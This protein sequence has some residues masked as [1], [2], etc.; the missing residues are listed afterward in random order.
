M[1][2]DTSQD[3]VC[4]FWDGVKLRFH[5]INCCILGELSGNEPGCNHI[6]PIV[7][8]VELEQSC[9]CETTS[10]LNRTGQFKTERTRT[11]KTNFGAR[12]EDD[13]TSS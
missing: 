4:L 11:W 7:N 3:G 8:I 10:K 13:A 9:P 6:L 2:P 12:G 1:V 5:T